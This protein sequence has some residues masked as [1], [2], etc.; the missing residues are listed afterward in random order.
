MRAKAK[1]A[2]IYFNTDLSIKSIIDNF[3]EYCKPLFDRFDKEKFIN[4]FIYIKQHDNETSYY[5]C[6]SNGC[7]DV[8]I[9]TLFLSFAREQSVNILSFE[10]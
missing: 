2:C 3:V 9:G 6:F 8:L 10:Y 4:E 5:T 7:E 1:D